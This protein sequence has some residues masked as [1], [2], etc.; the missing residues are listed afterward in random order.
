[1]YN[2]NQQDIDKDGKKQFGSLTPRGHVTCVS[3]LSNGKKG[4]KGRRSPHIDNSNYLNSGT[5]YL[6]FSHIKVSS[7]GMCNVQARV[8]FATMT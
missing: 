4:A 6:I 2:A 5:F 1:M 8:T 7:N 3:F